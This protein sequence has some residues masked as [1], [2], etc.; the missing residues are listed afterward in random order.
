MK[1]LLI[2]VTFIAPL[3]L[4]SSQN[5][6]FTLSPTIASACDYCLL[7]RGFEP[8]ETLRGFE[9]GLDTRYTV[10]NSVFSGTRK[11][12]NRNDEKETH[13]TTQFRL[14]YNLSSRVTISGI[15]PVP[16]RSVS[17]L[18]TEAEHGHE[19]EEG[20][21]EE[22]NT[23]AVHQ[24]NVRGSAL[25]FGDLTVLG[26]YTFLRLS[27]FNHATT[28]ALE[29]GLKLPTGKTSAMDAQGDFLDAHIQPGTGSWNFLMGL[30]LNHG[31]N[32]FGLSGRLLY[33]INTTGEAGDS[34]YKYGNWLNADIRVKYGILTTKGKG[35]NLSIILGVNGEFRG[36]EE[37]AGQV[38]GNTGGKVLYFSPGFQL[39]VS[40]GVMVEGVFQQPFF[41]NLNGEEQLGEALKASFGLNLIL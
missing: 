3:L 33:S 25:H 29:G 31:N 24:H 22:H 26:K 5:S 6:G 35:R 41:H 14:T 7:T 9:F 8:L 4:G 34:A 10:L 13:F 17:L 37:A 30:S 39:Q 16:R 15:L 1:K 12:M 36:R 2:I 11:V 40:R 18:S 20:G 21:H 23:G 32:H 28:V 27:T 38:L 19:A